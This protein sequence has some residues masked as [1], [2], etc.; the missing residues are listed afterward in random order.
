MSLNECEI[1]ANLVEAADFGVAAT[2]VEETQEAIEQQ[3]LDEESADSEV[4]G[5][6]QE[7]QERKATG[8]PTEDEEAKLEDDPNTPEHEDLKSTDP[9][10]DG[11]GWNVGDIWAEGSAA[12]M[13]GLRDTASSAITLPERI[14]DMFSGEMQREGEDY[15]PDFD[16]LGGDRNPIVKTWWGNVLR[17]I[18]HFGSTGAAITAAVAALPVSAGAA[19][20]TGVAATGAKSISYLQRLEGLRKVGSGALGWKKMMAFDGAIGASSDLV[21]EYSQDDNSMGALKEHFPALDTPLA[22]NDQ[23]SPMVM[24]AKNVMEGLGIGFAAGGLLMVLGKALGGRFKGTRTKAAG[25][26]NARAQSKRVTMEAN[27]KADVEGGIPQRTPTERAID[28]QIANRADV[29]EQIKEMGEMQLELPGFG[30][31]KSKYVLAD[32]D[33]GNALPRGRAHTIMKQLDEIDNNGFDGELGST[34]ATVTPAQLRRSN[35]IVDVDGKTYEDVMKRILGEDRFAR[36]IQEAADNGMSAREV[37]RSSYKRM[38]DLVEV[39][40]TPVL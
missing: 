32:D 15:A 4:A 17:G 37:F 31:Y 29:D 10:H 8:A 2:N 28:Q 30:G 40:T 20:A 3:R 36:L 14:G 6:V 13:G 27:A 19:T 25:D 12:V 7:N 16:P 11:V 33:M 35:E 23:D 26:S 39:G 21:S 24:T 9:R 34:Y 22:T 38:Q 18:V 5:A 1:D